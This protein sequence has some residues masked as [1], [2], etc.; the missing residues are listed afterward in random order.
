MNEEFIR[1]I[2]G[3]T[4]SELI[5]LKNALLDRQ[6]SGPAINSEWQKEYLK[7]LNETLAKK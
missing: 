3:K 1:R 2:Q 6:A 4:R 5:E 7:L